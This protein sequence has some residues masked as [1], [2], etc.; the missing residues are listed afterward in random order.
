MTTGLSTTNVAN[1]IC[2]VYRGAGAGTN[3]NA[4]AN[5]YI[6]CHIGDPGAAGASNAAALTTRSLATLG[7][8]ASGANALSNSP[9]FSA[10]ATET[11]SH[12]SVWDNLTAGNFQWSVAL[13]AP[14]TVANGDTLTAT[15]LGLSFAP[16]AA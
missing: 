13:S 16:L 3:L 5:I 11:I 4:P 6:K 2:N 7:A 15:A 10:V 9:S 12:I 1:A 8:A 14:K